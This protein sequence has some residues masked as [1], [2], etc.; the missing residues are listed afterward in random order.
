MAQKTIRKK[1]KKTIRTGTKTCLTWLKGT[2][3]GKTQITKTAWKGT[4][5]QGTIISQISTIH[6]SQDLNT[7]KFISQEAIGKEWGKEGREKSIAE[8]A[9]NKGGIKACKKV[10]KERRRH[11]SKTVASWINPT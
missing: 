7:S 1:E 9:I 3:K 4:N 11:F 5:A 8:T 10:G 6:R 2:W